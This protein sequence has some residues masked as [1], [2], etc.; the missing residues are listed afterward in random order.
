M[1]GV[2]KAGGAWLPLDPS[3]PADRLA[4][5]L[6]DAAVPVLV[7]TDA[8]ADELP[9]PSGMLVCV[10]AEE[11]EIAAQR[12]DA[13]PPTAVGP[14][15]L[16]YVIYTSGSTG[17]PKGTLLTHAG[18]CNT[19]LAAAAG[20]DLGPDSR[21]LQFAASGFDAS[22]WEIFST[23]LVGGRLCLAPQQELLPG[24][25][26]HAFLKR[27][28][29]TAVTL[30]PTALAPTSSEGLPALVTVTAAGEASTPELAR[31]WS[32]G[33]R[34]I[35]AYGPTEVT[36]CAT[37]CRDVVPEHLTIGGPLPGVRVY[38]LDAALRP[39]P[40]GVPGELYVGGVGL[41][42]GYLGRPEL[43][44]ERFVPNPFATAPGERMYRTGDVVRWRTSGEL[45]FVGRADTQVKI[46]GFRIELGEIEAALSQHPEVQEAVVVVRDEVSGQRRLVAYLTPRDEA[47]PET[48]KLR[49]FLKERLPEYMVP[50][51]F[52][53]LES[54]PLS[55]AGKVDR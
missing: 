16:A 35:N 34:F 38:V 12:A 1:L 36:I 55:P 48:A 44:A 32:Q 54:F 14:E 11:D 26:L 24:E 22:V 7:T 39:A 20:L 40:V 52:V 46:R 4:Y 9:S 50:A 30:T 2:L 18:L 37:L 27:E 17:R 33:R 51:T 47:A 13:P 5:M 53:T 25:A 31:R 41:A 3:Y 45:E 21:V 43:S 23:L 42:R 29:V 8:L 49:T 28:G 15:H 6:A 10:D 19:A